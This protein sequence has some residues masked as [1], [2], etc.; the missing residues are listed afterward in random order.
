[1][2]GVDTPIDQLEL[3]G[4][5]VEGGGH[6]F[7]R[8]LGRGCDATRFV[9]FPAMD[10]HPPLLLCWFRDHVTRDAAGRQLCKEVRFTH[11]STSYTSRRQIVT[12]HFRPQRAITPP[13]DGPR[14]T[15]SRHRCVRTRLFPHRSPTPAPGRLPAMP[16]RR[17]A[18]RRYPSAR[19]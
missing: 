5:L 1:M 13:P 15:R 4:R 17:D 9:D 18:P 7:G 2:N 14:R 8:V 10:S 11:S 6:L 16:P 19:S 3:E 12:R